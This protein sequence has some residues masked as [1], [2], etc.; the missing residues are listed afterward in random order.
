VLA[1]LPG[2][3]RGMAPTRT[4]LIVTTDDFSTQIVDRTTG[5]VR[6]WI[7]SGRIHAFAASYDLEVAAYLSATGT[8]ELADLVAGEHWPIGKRELLPTVGNVTLSGDGRYIAAQLQVSNELHILRL[9]LPATAA[10]TAAWLDD[11]TNGVVA[12]GTTAVSWPR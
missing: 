7:A 2:E 4:S 12:P 9:E 11:L 6:P 1:T 10:A 5:Q 3:I 8:L